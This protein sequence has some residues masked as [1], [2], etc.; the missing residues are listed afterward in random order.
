MAVTRVGED[1]EISP[2]R[3]VERCR[4]ARRETR[5]P[6]LPGGQP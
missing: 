2:H 1:L 5:N 6:V 4:G 3:T